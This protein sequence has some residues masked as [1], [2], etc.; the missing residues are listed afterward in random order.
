MASYGVVWD[1]GDLVRRLCVA[2]DIAIRVTQK[3]APE[4]YFNPNDSESQVGSTKV[5]AETAM[6]LLAVAPSARRFLPVRERMNL[7]AGLLNPLA[8]SNGMRAGLCLHPVLAWDYAFAH[9]CLTRLGFPDTDFD[10]LFRNSL[11]AEEAAGQERLP[12]R[13][14]ERLWLERVWSENVGSMRRDF[15]VT[16]AS[17]IGRTMDAL[18]ASR[19]DVYALTHALVYVTD[20][21]QRRPRLPRS[22]RAILAD[23]E[24][25]LARCLDMEDYDLGGE[26]LLAWPLLAHRWSPTASFGFSVLA[27]VEDE[28]GFLPAPITRLDRYRA[29]DHEA[30]R[31]RYALATAYHTGYVMGLLCAI[32][33]IPDR[34]RPLEKWAYGTRRSARELALLLGLI[35]ESGNQPH[36]LKN[37]CHLGPPQQRALTPM[38][39]SIALQRAAAARDL[40]RL[41]HALEVA[42]RVGLAAGPSPRQAARLLRRAA[43]SS[44]ALDT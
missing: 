42:V 19:D 39:L 2:L 34:S 24:T 3:L 26:V 29:L 37:F 43:C 25:A 28:V 6:L 33:L 21:G 9:V 16:N 11:A 13:T 23:A 15:V 1:E 12:Y 10:E 40:H 41:R 17:M 22:R 27:R 4:D 30:E 14:L 5:I 32:A 18:T 36:W 31:T 35:E 8:R 44:L 38:L 7:V 20:L